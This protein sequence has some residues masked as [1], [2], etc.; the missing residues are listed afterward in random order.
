M[1]FLSKFNYQFSVTTDEEALHVQ[2]DGAQLGKNALQAQAAAA[3]VVM[4]VQRHQQLSD[5]TQS[6]GLKKREAKAN[7]KIVEAIEKIRRSYS[8]MKFF[9]QFTP[10]V[11]VDPYAAHGMHYD[12]PGHYI[13]HAGLEANTFQKSLQSLIVNQNRLL[14]VLMSEE[15][16]S[17]H[18]GNLYSSNLFGED[19]SQLVDMQ[20]IQAAKSGSQAAQ[21]DQHG[22]S[23][24]TNYKQQQIREALETNHNCSSL[25]IQ[26]AEDLIMPEITSYLETNRKEIEAKKQQNQEEDPLEA[27][28]SQNAMEEPSEQNRPILHGSK[29]NY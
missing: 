24:V 9:E 2:G 13:Q 23:W 4:G 15:N 29:A 17:S 5:S 10:P 3:H 1:S 18:C 14:Q 25:F 7:E 19:L 21:F 28:L 11:E 8:H 27:P 20:R 22:N 26:E 12:L 16:F 6:H